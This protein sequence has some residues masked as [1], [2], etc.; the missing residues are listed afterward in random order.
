MM[1]QASPQLLSNIRSYTAELERRGVPVERVILF[2]SHARGDVHAHSDIDLAVFSE[3]FG[4][5]DHVEFS[6]VL[7]AA[8]WN[9]EP[10]I[11]AIGFNP[12]VL[13]DISPVS[14]LHEIM[15]TG[16]VVYQRPQ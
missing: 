6:G 10:M 9:T 13:Q 8:K 4:G 14:L 3:A 1:A 16:C 7:S 12:A 11:E 15:S 2:G 5:R